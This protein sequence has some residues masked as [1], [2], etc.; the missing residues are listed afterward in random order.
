MNNGNEIICGI[1]LRVSTEDQA[2]EGFSLGEQKERLEAFCKFHGYKIYDYYED[3][4]ISAKKG[5]KRPNFERLIKDAKSGKLN[6]I[7]ALKLDRISRSVYDWENI[8]NMCEENN[9]NLICANDDINTTTAN[10]KMITRIMMSVSQNEI[11]RTS[12]RTKIGMA[13]AIKKGHIPNKAPLGFTRDGKRLVPD[14]LTKNIAKRIFELYHNGYSYFKIA[15]IYNKEKVLNK[16]N[17]SDVTILQIISNEIYKGDYVHGKITKTP[18]YYEDVVE[19]IVSKELWEECQVQ[20]KRNSR[21][22]KRSLSYVYLQKLKCPNCN[23]IMGGKATTKK[24]GKSYFYY[25]CH[26]CKFHI[27]EKVI[28]EHM[29][30]FITEILEYD[31]IVNQFFLPMLKSKTNNSKE[32]IKTSIKEQKQMLTR[33]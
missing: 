23:R 28:D 12:E 22:Y 33:I 26:E 24:S 4:G 6:T 10:G 21:S 5:N 2:R 1:Y 31:K 19:P 14:P 20:K 7:L 25:Q 13:G 18:K 30:E 3:A 15:N 16:T 27:N 11:E 32:A 17:W 29:E 9:I 8:M